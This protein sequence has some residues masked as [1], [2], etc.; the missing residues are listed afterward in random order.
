M[1]K[2]LESLGDEVFDNTAWYNSQ[3]D[4]VV[5]LGTIVY[6][7]KGK[8]PANTSITIKDGTTLIGN[9]AFYNCGGFWAQ[10]EKSVDNPHAT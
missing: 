9:E 3:D 5:Y 1:S 4:G 7:Y 10:G 2:N 8:M 6:K